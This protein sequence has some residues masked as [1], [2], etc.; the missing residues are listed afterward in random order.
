MQIKNPELVPIITASSKF[1]KYV[2]F[3]R[4]FGPA[5]GFIVNILPWRKFF[6]KHSYLIPKIY[7]T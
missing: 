6:Y 2:G 7:K 4:Q 1:I 3:D 5:S